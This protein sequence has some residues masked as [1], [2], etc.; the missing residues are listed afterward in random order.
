M[1][2]LGTRV[3]DVLAPSGK[4]NTGINW[5]DKENVV[6]INERKEQWCHWVGWKNGLKKFVEDVKGGI[7]AVMKK[8]NAECD[9]IHP[10]L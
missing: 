7:L 5:A 10:P 8:R 9:V 3:G 6:L 4:E 2:D 1:Q